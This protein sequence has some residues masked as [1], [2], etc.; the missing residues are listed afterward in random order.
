MSLAGYYAL[1]YALVILACKSD[2]HRVVSPSRANTIGKQYD[3][4]LI[5]VSTNTELGK[6]KI[7][8]CFVWEIKAIGRHRRKFCQLQ[9]DRISN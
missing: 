1:G 6:Q 9:S 8:N 4:G 5:E 7:R 2:L 3:I